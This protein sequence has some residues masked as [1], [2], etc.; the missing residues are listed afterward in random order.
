MSLTSEHLDS[1]KSVITT[2]LKVP[3]LEFNEFIVTMF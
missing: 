3:Y 2:L 1:L